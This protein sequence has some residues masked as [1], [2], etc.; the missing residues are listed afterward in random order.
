MMNLENIDELIAL[1]LAGE[2]DPAGEEQLLAWINES[3]ANANHFAMMQKIWDAGKDDEGF[4]PDVDAAWENVAEELNLDDRSRIIEMPKR[5]NS[6]FYRIAAAIVILLGVTWI[7]TNQLSAPEMIRVASLN[8]QKEV[9]LPDNSK[10][11][12]NANTS[13]EYPEHFRGNTREIKLNGEAFFEITKDRAHPFIIHTENVYT[14]VLGTSFNI[15]ARNKSNKVV[16]SVKT[17]KVEVGIDQQSNVKLEPGY[18]AMVDLTTN[19]LEKINTPSD[20]Y[21]SWKTKELIFEDVT[22]AELIPVLNSY[23]NI[24]IS[25]NQEILDCHFTGKFSQ[26]NLTDILNVLELSNGFSYEINGDK[27]TLTG[28]ACR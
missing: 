6:I 21:L 19:S 16:V 3:E 24:E 28:K 27:I 13:I 2:I 4:N 15:L 26:P 17:G 8:E 12:L 5:S 22:I 14:K 25:A 11:Y 10:V 7:Y 1:K 18:T 20:N 23:Y 9:I